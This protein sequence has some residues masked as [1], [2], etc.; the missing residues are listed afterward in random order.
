MRTTKKY[1]IGKILHDP[2]QRFYMKKSECATILEIVMEAIKEAIL[3]QKVVELRG[4]GSVGIKDVGPKSVYN[5]KDGS[6]YTKEHILKL[7]FSP[8]PVVKGEIK[9][10]NTKLDEQSS[11]KTGDDNAVQ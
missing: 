7:K 5:F 10:I 9:A 1:F 4:I 2:R 8:S 6:T 3:E 11:K